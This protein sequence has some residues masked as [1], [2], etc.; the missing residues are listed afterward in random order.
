MQYA[1]MQELDAL[2]MSLDFK[3]AFDR[4]EI[5]CLRGGTKIFQFW[6]YIF[7]KWIELLLSGFSDMYF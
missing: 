5:D 7:I 2:I 1:E 6:G 3:K 4:V